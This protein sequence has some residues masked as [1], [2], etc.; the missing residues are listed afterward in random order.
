[1]LL[2][3]YLLGDQE[4]YKK[5]CTKLDAHYS[6]PEEIDDYKNLID[7]P[8][9]SGTGHEGLRLGTV[10]GSWFV[11][12]VRWNRP[13]TVFSMA[14]RQWGPKRV[15]VCGMAALLPVYALFPVMSSLAKSWGLSPFV[16]VAL[17]VQTILAIIVDMAY[18]ELAVSVKDVAQCNSTSR[19]YV[20][21]HHSGCPKQAGAQGHEQTLADE[22]VHCACNGTGDVHVSVHIF[23]AA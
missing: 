15:F 14:V 6:G 1:M 12:F 20:Y 21:V 7:L 19:L 13:G 2:L 10:S 4:T 3:Y 16:W 5:L 8:Y 11:W 18:G 9:L 22:C 17:M 23:G